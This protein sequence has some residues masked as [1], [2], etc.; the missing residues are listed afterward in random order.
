M[1]HTFPPLLSACPARVTAAMANRSRPAP[2]LDLGLAKQVAV[3]LR[4]Q[5]VA[6][7]RPLP[8]HLP[9]VEQQVIVFPHSMRYLPGTLFCK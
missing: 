7:M 3:A 5:E 4:V 9:Q 8:H 1:C 6:R 2:D